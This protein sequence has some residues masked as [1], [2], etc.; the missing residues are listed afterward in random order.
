M[1]A[2]VRTLELISNDAARPHLT[3][4]IL[5]NLEY[6]DVHTARAIVPNAFGSIGQGKVMTELKNIFNATRK[7]F[8]ETTGVRV[9]LRAGNG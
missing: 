1:E 3:T 4:K 2:N 9:H 6:Q 8:I 5:H 7:T